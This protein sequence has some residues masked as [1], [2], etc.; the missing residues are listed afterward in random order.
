MPGWLTWMLIILAGW[1][2]GSFAVA[3][4]V[5]HLL[6][7]LPASD[8]LLSRTREEAAIT[9]WSDAPLTRATASETD[10]LDPISAGHSRRAVH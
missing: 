5:A 10:E 7:Q 6:K 2:F 8:K 3:F 1:T 9:F 4:Y